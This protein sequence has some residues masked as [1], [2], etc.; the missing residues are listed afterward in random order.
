[1]EPQ[2]SLPPNQR[3]AAPGRWPVVG[4]RL[5]RQKDDRPWSLTVSGVVDRPCS[6]SLDSLLTRP[7]IE[8]TIDIHCVTR[9]SRPSVTFRGI[10]L[11]EIFANVGVLPTARFVWMQ[12][13]S[14]RSHG[15]SVPLLTAV[16]CGALIAWEADGKPL[17][18]EHGGPLRIVVP[19]RYFYKSV[20][21]IESLELLEY[22][23]LGWW[24][25]EAGYHNN[26]DPS[27]EE[28]YVA[29]A[30][31]R[32]VA[33]RLVEKR[34]VSGLDLLGFD[35]C[36]RD[37]TGLDAREAVLRDARFEHCQLARADFGGANLSNA[38]FAHS[39]L[40]RSS[41]RGADCEGAD[42]AGCDLR[43]SDFRGASLFGATFDNAQL[44]G[45]LFD[46]GVDPHCTA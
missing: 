30:I 4:E 10:L 32:V 39:L 41:F 40:H 36:H 17:T 9:W 35:A 19:G 3:W 18:E 38:R 44:D 15:S 31:D 22:D 46:V 2:G 25:S 20:K 33:A 43:E 13:R 11:E 7:S 28:R 34:D 29:R 16:E 6:W 45:C 27:R 1:M 12:A 42:F 37:L 5:P 23:R 26:A 8:R 14:D 24:E 21:W